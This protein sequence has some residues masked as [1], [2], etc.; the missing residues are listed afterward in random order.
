MGKVQNNTGEARVI[1]SLGGKYVKPS[2]IFDVPDDQVYGLTQCGSYETEVD[3]ETVVVGGWDPVDDAA[4]AAHAEAHQAYLERRSAELGGVP[5][6]DNGAPLPPIELEEPAGNAS[7]EEWAEYVVAARLATE[8]EIDGKGR[9]E[10]RDTYRAPEP[11][12]D[13]DVT[14]PPG[15]QPADDDNDTDGS[16]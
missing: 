9:D 5:V 13:D 4:K 7:R 3:G 6:D 1:P 15:D 8:D 2:Q 11:D 10:L 16:N 14:D 12:E